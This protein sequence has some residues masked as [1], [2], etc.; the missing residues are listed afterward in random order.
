MTNELVTPLTGKHIRKITIPKCGAIPI[1]VIEE[2][3]IELSKKRDW[4]DWGNFRFCCVRPKSLGQGWNTS[5]IGYFVN[6]DILNKKIR[7]QED[8]I[9][10]TKKMTFTE[11]INF[12]K[13]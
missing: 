13:K 5:W 7:R 1:S 12:Q 11:W 8:K 9:K 2:R 3:L 6:M 10:M 4:K